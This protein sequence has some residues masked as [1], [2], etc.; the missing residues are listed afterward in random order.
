MSVILPIHTTIVFFDNSTGSYNLR[1]FERDNIQI[2]SLLGAFFYLLAKYLLYFVLYLRL[3]HVLKDSMFNYSQ[4]FYAKI[5]AVILVSFI[6][7]ISAI[8]FRLIDV[9]IGILIASTIY[10]LI[11]LLFPIWLNILFIKKLYQIGVFVI[12][13]S[14]LKSTSM[15]TRS[16]QDNNEKTAEKSNQSQESQL[17]GSQGSKESKESKESKGSNGS[18]P[19]TTMNH[20]KTTSNKINKISENNMNPTSS[21]TKREG[22]RKP[23]AT[24]KLLQTISRFSVLSFLIII[25][26]LIFLIVTTIVSF[27][28]GDDTDT[29]GGL[30]RPIV[31]NLMVLDACTNEIC[32]ILYFEFVQK[33]YGI[34][35]HCCTTQRVSTIMPKICLCHYCR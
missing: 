7:A 28:I 23:V 30:A 16:D 21:N 26:S 18:Q 15:T 1:E 9:W 31:W 19:Q 8:L 32:L 2:S 29:G 27:S 24:D 35:C 6:C 3:Y 13:S 10:F 17:Q 11:D 33:L 12:N 5:Q 22:Q 25:S 4:S 34:L 14:K 20:L